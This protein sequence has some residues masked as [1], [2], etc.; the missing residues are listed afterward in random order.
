MRHVSAPLVT[1]K[2]TDGAPW[3]PAFDD[4]PLNVRIR[5]L[6]VLPIGRQT[7]LTRQDESEAPGRFRL[8]DRGLGSLARN[9]VHRI[10]VDALLDGLT[11]YEDWVEVQAGLLTAPVAAFVWL[12]F[13]WRQHRWRD[14]ARQRFAPLVADAPPAD[15]D[16]RETP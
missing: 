16:K 8:Y 4:A 1:F 10:T 15:E 6:G 11:L 2:R 3:P 12:F 5:L 13:A 7:I 9:W 14:L